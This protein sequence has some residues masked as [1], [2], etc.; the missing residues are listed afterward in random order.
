MSAE[1]PERLPSPEDN[2][3]RAVLI[4]NCQLSSE[5]VGQIDETARDLS[6]SFTRTAVQLGFVSEE[7][8]RDAE[9]YARRFRD[10]ERAGPI[11]A[12]VR[13]LSATPRRRSVN[14]S[15]FPRTLNPLLVFVREPYNEHSEKLRALRTELL[16]LMQ[17]QSQPCAL[18]IASAFAGEG[19]SQL[20][21]E[22]AIAFAQLGRNTL[23]VD[24]DMRNPRQHLLF[25]GPDDEE[26]L[27]HALLSATLPQVHEV[28]GQPHLY[29]LPT[30]PTPPNPLELLSTHYFKRLVSDWRSTFDFIVFDTPPIGAYADGLAIATVAE[31][32]LVLS[33][34][35]HT[36]YRG[37]KDMLRRLATAETRIM[38]AVI[39]HF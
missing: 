28:Q 32:S 38:G 33:R 37:F 7:E 10:T 5:K 1:M 31:R 36:T 22:L 24:A 3:L 23:L 9:E 25:E 21:A 15:D 13:R 8:L 27:A 19:R 2:V 29:V 39:N 30:G 26:G 35:E 14:T 12:A 17:Q 6:L 16:L 34:A 11:E 20:A 4:S 18:A